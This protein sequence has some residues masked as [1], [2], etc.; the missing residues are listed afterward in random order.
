M[1]ELL[2]APGGAPS[3]G[4]GHEPGEWAKQFMWKEQRCL[5]YHSSPI[6]ASGGHGLCCVIWSVNNNTAAYILA[7]VNLPN[8][9]L[10]F[11]RGR[12]GKDRMCLN[13]NRVVSLGFAPT[14]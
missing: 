3:D 4:R 14:L 8:L 5:L 9:S 10:T 6:F 2:Q 11:I 1:S 13:I 7:L 12:N